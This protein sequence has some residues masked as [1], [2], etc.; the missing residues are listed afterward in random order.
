MPF[1]G[2][3]LHNELLEGVNSIIQ[4]YQ[5]KRWIVGERCIVYVESL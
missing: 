2:L 1:G 4:N 5:E 3:E